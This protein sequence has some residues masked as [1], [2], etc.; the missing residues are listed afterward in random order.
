MKILLIQPYAG[1]EY[2]NF[3]MK[4][5]SKLPVMPNLT[6][7]QLAGICPEDCEI[8]AIEENHGEK[9]N[10][11]N[12]Y[13]IV[14]ISCRTANA[15]RAYEIADKFRKRAIPVIFGGSHPSALPE[16]AKQ[17]ADCV[18]IGEAEISL[19]KIFEDLKKNKLKPYYQSDL[20][21][22]KDIPNAKRDVIKYYLSIAAIEATRGCPINCDFC[23]VHKVKG[24]IHRKRP[25]ENVIE[26]IKTIKQKTIMFFDASLTTDPS[27]TKT[28]FKNLIGLNKQLTCYGNV[29]ILAKD[30][31]FLK[32]AN[33][34]GC[35]SWCIGFEA[36]SQHI[37]NN[38][39][40]TTNKIKDYQSA[41]KKIKDYDM[42]ICGSFIFGFDDHG[43]NT[44]KET[45]DMINKLD[46]DVSCFNILTPFPGTKLFERIKSENRITSYDWAQY[47]CADT[48]FKPINMSEK[49]L[50]KGTIWVLKNYYKFFP[51]LK[52][53]IRNIPHGYHPFLNSIYGN[54][55]FY[56]RKFDPGRN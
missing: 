41:I 3:V 12:D 32:L 22:P 40:K 48:V 29:N 4:L 6:L 10:F 54:S 9:I 21:N 37:I 28:L 44:F 17:H 25:I 7:Q 19:K 56:S 33:E 8:E 53:I 46:I 55:V 1:Y 20:V 34:A 43:T 26:E 30:D 47:T 24:K 16:E 39:G 5:S 36:L 38:I 27:Y 11:D 49:E 35:I 18:V 45:I 42:N 13:D 14:A 31:E 52:R 23:F 50:Y 15:P 2:P 51:T